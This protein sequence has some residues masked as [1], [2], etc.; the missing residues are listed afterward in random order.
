MKLFTLLS[1]LILT[2]LAASADSIDLIPARWL[3]A[4]VYGGNQASLTVDARSA[5]L[6]LPCAFG[7]IPHRPVIDEQGRFTI[8]GT[9]SS[10]LLVN[11]PQPGLPATFSGR[12][13]GAAVWVQVVVRGRTGIQQSS[14]GPLEFGQQGRFFRCL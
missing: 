7:K 6:E 2:P 13:V 8:E 1:V 12:I 5:Q 3:P 14:Y 11:P 9:Y 4:G 10:R